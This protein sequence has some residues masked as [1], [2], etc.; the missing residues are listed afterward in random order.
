MCDCISKGPEGHARWSIPI[1]NTTTALAAAAVVAL[2]AVTAPTNSEARPF[3]GWRGGG[4]HHAGW[5]GGWRH[6]GWH[7][8][9]GFPVAPVLGGLAAGALL[10]AAL[11]APAYA[12]PV[13]YDTYA[14]DPFY[15]PVVAGPACV[16]RRE[17][18]WNGWR[19]IIHRVQVCY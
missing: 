3:G 6:A 10:G 2:A 13:Y 9:R 7:H 1:A 11:S 15:T 12:A 4:W 5:H 19:W 18:I 16:L 17:R 8:R 14:Y